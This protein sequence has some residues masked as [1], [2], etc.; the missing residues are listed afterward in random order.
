MCEC[1][2]V[3]VYVH[4]RV[5]VHAFVCA[6]MR[7]LGCVWLCGGGLPVCIGVAVKGW[8]WSMPL[9]LGLLETHLGCAAVRVLRAARPSSAWEAGSALW[10]C[11]GL[12]VGRVAPPPSAQEDIRQLLWSR[13]WWVAP[14]CPQS[15]HARCGLPCSVPFP[16]HPRQAPNRRPAAVT[17][18][19]RQAT[20][21]PSRR[22]S[23]AWRTTYS[24]ASSQVST[25]AGA[26]CFQRCPGTRSVSAA[27][28]CM[29]Q[30]ALL[31][32]AC[33]C[34][35]GPCPWCESQAVPCR[36][37]GAQ[38]SRCISCSGF[39]LS[40]AQQPHPAR[41][42]CLPAAAVAVLCSGGAAQDWRMGLP[43]GTQHLL[44]QR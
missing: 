2:C 17:A 42:L 16:F 38:L 10:L 31:T 32:C 36:T 22:S 39:C 43:A 35:P 15:N 19:K 12:E 27:Y 24:Q 1:L 4:L 5:C 29:L 6:C 26:A 37:C 30:L 34:Q 20:R 23:C 13:A 21:T 14:C 9:A 25:P 7:M 11:V 33:V 44:A 8:E 40:P 41:H 28:V 3:H 18:A